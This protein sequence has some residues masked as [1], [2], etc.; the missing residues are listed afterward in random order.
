[1]VESSRGPDAFLWPFVT[2]RVAMD[3]A[4]NASI[5]CAR[6]AQIAL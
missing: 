2:G 1:M 5:A 4:M 6:M 3:M